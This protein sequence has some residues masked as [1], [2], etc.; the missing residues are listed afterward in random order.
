MGP[1][2]VVSYEVGADL[3]F[4]GAS[5]KPLCCHWPLAWVTHCSA[6]VGGSP[7]LLAPLWAPQAALLSLNDIFIRLV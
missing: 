1:L 7:G 3:R 4:L 2:G 6:L 5:P